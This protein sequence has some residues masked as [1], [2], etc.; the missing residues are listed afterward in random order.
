MP[1]ILSLNVKLVLIKQHF[2]HV[3]HLN[4]S[5]GSEGKTLGMGVFC[6]NR[7]KS[8]ENSDWIKQQWKYCF[9][10]F[11]PIT[12]ISH[13]HP[14]Y[15]LIWDLWLVENKLIEFTKGQLSWLILVYLFDMRLWFMLCCFE[16]SHFYKYLTLFQFFLQSSCTTLDSN[17]SLNESCVLPGRWAISYL[18][19]RQPVV[20]EVLWS[21]T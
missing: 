8:L 17:N 7:I 20:E 11:S 1:I 12:H 18:R 2:L 10:Y 16:V 14:D 6:F 13:L 21:F 15:S 5:W 19:Y 4:P 9:F 3:S